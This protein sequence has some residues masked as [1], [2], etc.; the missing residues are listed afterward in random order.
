MSFFYAVKKGHHP[1]IY[2]T[3]EECQSQIEGFSGDE[4]KKFKKIEEATAFI[5]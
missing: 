3:W 1:D 2:Q 5:Q 4:F